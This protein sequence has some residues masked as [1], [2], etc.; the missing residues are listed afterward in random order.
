MPQVLG[1]L[2]FSCVMVGQKML[3][4]VMFVRLNNRRVELTTVLDYMHSERD[5]RRQVEDEYEVFKAAA[6]EK[7]PL[8]TVVSYV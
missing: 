6:Q 1:S 4:A 7:G 8:S 5:S 2:L 3:V